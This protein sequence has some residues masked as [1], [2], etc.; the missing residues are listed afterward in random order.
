MGILKGSVSYIPDR[1]PNEDFFVMID[2]APTDKFQLKSGY[3]LKGEII[4]ERLKIYQF[5]LK[6]LF[7]KLD[8]TA[9]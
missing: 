3:S 9:S 1:K 6:K 8:D 4:I 5:I 7:K 2:V